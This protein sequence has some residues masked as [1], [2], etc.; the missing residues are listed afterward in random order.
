MAALTSTIGVHTLPARVVA[1]IAGVDIRTVE[2]WRARVRPRP[3][4]QR[5]LDELDAVLV[6]LGTGMSATA[7]RQWLEAPNAALDWDRPTDVLAA[8]G[9]RRVLAAAQVYLTGDS[10]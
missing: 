10:S 1:A 2:R 5:R 9:F 4:H 3:R 8:G 6:V 7:K